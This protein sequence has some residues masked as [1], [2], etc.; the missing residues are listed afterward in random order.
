[1]PQIL[2]RNN[3]S[4][5]TFIKL[6]ETPEERLQRLIADHK[7]KLATSFEEL[8]GPAT[9]QTQEEIQ[10]EVNDFLQMREEWRKP[11]YERNFD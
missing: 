11:L 4:G 8:L 9:G 5:A 6:K 1:M 2:E 7:G 10:A 3:P